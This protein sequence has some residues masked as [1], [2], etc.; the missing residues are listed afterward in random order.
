MTDWSK[1]L[2]DII[3]NKRVSCKI[4]L[5]NDIIEYSLQ[6]MIYLVALSVV[7]KYSHK[8]NMFWLLESR[9]HHTDILK[10]NMNQNPD[11]LLL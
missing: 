7:S 10:I 9:D 2:E 8:L 4:V 11:M 1:W 5:R 3:N 6:L